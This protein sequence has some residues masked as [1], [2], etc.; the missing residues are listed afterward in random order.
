[1]RSAT[2]LTLIEVVVAIAVLV[3]GIFAAV[4]FQVSSLRATSLSEITQQLSRI[5]QAEVEWRRQTA[6]DLGTHDCQTFRPAEYP[7]CTV[8][9]T[10]CVMLDGQYGFTCNAS[11]LSPIAYRVQVNVVGPREQQF[12]LESFYTGIYVAGSTGS[13]GAAWSYPA[14]EPDSGTGAP[15][16]P[17]G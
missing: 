9:M 11:V 4:Q 10:P 6:I 8:T 7:S 5:G 17:G 3:V 13:Q 12:D 2:G 1:M 15:V 14:D 16:T